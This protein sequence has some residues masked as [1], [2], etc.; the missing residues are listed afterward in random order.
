MKLSLNW[1]KSFVDLGNI[2][3]EDLAYK[4]T[5]NAFEVEDVKIQGPDL[6]GPILVG[7]ILDIKK[8]PNA[9]RLQITSITTDGKN[10]LQIV[11]GANNIKI[12]QIVPVSLPGAEVLN[13]KDGTKLL[14]KKSKI[15]DIES[16]G[17]LCAPSELGLETEQ[18]DG[19]YILPEDAP[20]GQS[21]IDYLSLQK[22]IVLEVASRSNR[23]DALSVYGLSREI[24]ALFNK[25]IKK[26]DFNEPI[27]DESVN[28]TNPEI[29]NL[30]DT[31]LFYTVTIENVQ[32]KES[33]AWLKTLLSSIG[34]RSI[35]NIVDITNY[36][37]ATY[38]QPMHAYDKEKIVGKSLISRLSK[39][40]EEVKTLDDKLRILKEGILVIADSKGPV[41][42]AGVMGGKDSEV[43][44]TT[45]SIVF[46]AAVF[47]PVKVRKGSREVGLTSDS[48]KR[49]ERGVDSN[50]TY[51]ALLKAIELVQEIAIPGDK[52]KLKIGKIQ[53]SGKP[54]NKDLIIE[55]AK[56][57]I[58]RVLNINLSIEE[59]AKYLGSIGL[60]CK[61][62]SN[63]KIEVK[64]PSFRQN[65]LARSIDLVEEVARIHGYDKI[66]AEAP[67]STTSSKKQ[68]KILNKVKEHFISSGFSETYL[69][70]LIGEK[71]LKY[72]EFNFDDLKA[73]K[74]LNPLS[75]EHFVLRQSLLPGLLE[76]LKLNQSHQSEVLRLFETGKVFK[77]SNTS[78]ISEKETGIKEENHIS[79]VVYGINKDWY[80]NQLPVKNTNEFL[81]FSLKGILES[82]FQKLS[83][84]NIIFEKSQKGF[85]HPNIS[86][87][88]L[89]NNEN[90]GYIGCLHPSFEQKY[91]ISGPV[92]VLEINVE[93]LV[94]AAEDKIKNKIFT[95]IS[96][97]PILERDITVDIQKIYSAG[98]I[99]KELK[100]IA[101][102]FIKSISLISIYELDSS[103]RSLSFRLKMQDLEETLNSSLVDKEVEKLIKHLTSCFN[104]SFRV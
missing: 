3:P 74:M 11:C 65:D 87:E 103:S 102:S 10:N 93:S 80:K 69:S 41:A 44:D 14:I 101:P 61:I 1:L 38:G 88:I 46:E 78:L 91:E 13:R 18:Q 90:I 4:L 55:L 21:V 53:H 84:E 95:K 97:Q 16:E 36:I 100:K 63:E 35:N 98:E 47:N 7:K 5:M 83:I 59:I 29:E 79:A 40:G 82:L 92:I 81:F 45:K 51:K 39:N 58:K 85:L 52:N 33:P 99:I 19:I 26:T 71:I 67:K 57:E 60:E 15:R 64:I 72:E 9:D 75:K 34:I 76:A 17:M 24:S 8:H 56:S 27:F 50:F 2:S 37:N 30:N 86:L 77:I 73:I 42:L 31:Y 22:D 48:S 89:F 6:K 94:K 104:A 32:I 28:C 43:T 25:E 68:L 96:T 66:P 12:G 23:G 70:S 54:V 62:S 49:F 20:I